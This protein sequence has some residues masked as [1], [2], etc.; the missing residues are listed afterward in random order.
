MAVKITAPALSGIGELEGGVPWRK[1][2]RS[3]FALDLHTLLFLIVM[4]VLD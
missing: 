4:A 2:A 3:F 1:E